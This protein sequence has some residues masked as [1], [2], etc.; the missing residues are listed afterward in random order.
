MG[1]VPRRRGEPAGGQR[2]TAPKD[3]EPRQTH[4]RSK[5]V[6]H[7]SDLSDASP[8][9]NSG[10]S[11][12]PLVQVAGTGI[13]TVQAQIAP[14]IGGRA[15]PGRQPQPCRVGKSGWGFVAAAYS[16]RCPSDSRSRPETPNFQPHLHFRSNR[17]NLLVSLR[18]FALASNRIPDSHTSGCCLLWKKA[19]SQSSAEHSFPSHPFSQPA[20]STYCS[21]HTTVLT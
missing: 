2:G 10:I 14:R 16:A 7:I 6:F 13:S 11:N 12:P 19:S 15:A 5:C 4:A 1:S 17:P 3:G 8:M 21:F 9:R 18:H 20:S